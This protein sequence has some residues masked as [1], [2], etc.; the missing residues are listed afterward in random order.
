MPGQTPPATGQL[1]KRV[2]WWF[3]TIQLS[4]SSCH[5]AEGGRHHI[6]RQS[7]DCSGMWMKLLT[8]YPNQHDLV[9][10]AA[11]PLE[12]SWISPDPFVIIGRWTAEQSTGP[13]RDWLGWLG[14]VTATCSVRR[15]SLATQDCSLLTVDTSAVSRYCRIVLIVVS[16]GLLF[17]SCLLDTGSPPGYHSGSIHSFSIPLQICISE[18]EVYAA[19]VV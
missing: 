8:F 16:R 11:D 15:S 6:G 3:T 19:T 2:S 7:F 1:L 10:H 5:Q 17:L 18:S 12:P 13:V 14:V 9:R 4:R